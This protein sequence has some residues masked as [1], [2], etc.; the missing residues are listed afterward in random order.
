MHSLFFIVNIT[1]IQFI[2]L[3]YYMF[4]AY[5]Y[6]KTADQKHVTTDFLCN[7]APT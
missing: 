4:F 1:N 7:F 3:N 6:I 5:Y 2:T